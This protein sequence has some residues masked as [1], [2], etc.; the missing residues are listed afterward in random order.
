MGPRR[1]IEKVL[2]IHPPC[3]ILKRK[4]KYFSPPL[5]TLYLAAVLEE[6]GVE[7]M[8]LDAALEGAT[9]DTEVD[10]FRI[11]YGLPVDNIIEKILS[12]SP[13]IVGLSCVVSSQ[14][15]VCA[16]IVSKVKS[17]APGIITIMGGEHPSAMPREVALQS[18][19]DFIVIG[20][21]ERTLYDLVSCLTSGKDFDSIDGLAFKRG[22]RV[23]INS[24]TQFIEDIDSVPFPA[25]HLVD[26]NAYF[27]LNLPQGTTSLYKPNTSLITSRGCTAHCCF[28]ATTKFWGNRFRGRTPEDVVAEIEALIDKYGIREIQFLDD[29]L[30]LNKHRAARLFDLMVQKRLNI[31]WC[32]PQGLSIWSLDEQL[33][34]KMVASG[35]YEVTLAIE[36]GSQRVLNEIIKKPLQLSRIRPIVK[37]LKSHNIAV[38]SF[39]IVGL[40][41]ESKEEI[42]QTFSFARE[43]GVDTASFFAATPL[44]GTKLYKLCEEKGYLR[45]GFTLHDID[46]NRANIETPE[47]SPQY[48][49]Q[50]IARQTLVFNVSLVCR[51]PRAFYRKLVRLFVREPILVLKLVWSFL[52]AIPSIPLLSRRACGKRTR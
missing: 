13:D 38:H 39:F 43:A 5:G 10:S 37:K 18:H 29:N 2:L 27:E 35:C 1:R 22:S 8:V 6:M 32:T 47:F 52:A 19:A 20:E 34:E 49:E 44:P 16:E 45:N 50:Q 24:R 42:H 11:R 7:T 41:G 21:G 40:P 3:T 25:R 31:K 33:I 12:F 9:I 23:R 36:S 51:N 14:Y 28:C 17:I 46:Y 48:I 30:T 15:P 26:M 4:Y